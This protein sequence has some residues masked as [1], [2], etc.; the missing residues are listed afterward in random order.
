MQIA[1][2]FLTYSF[3][4]GH[5]GIRKINWCRD[6]L[7]F[8]VP[9]QAHGSQH[10]SNNFRP[11]APF[12]RAN[13]HL[14]RSP[15]GKSLAEWQISKST[16]PACKFRPPGH[17]N[18]TKIFWLSLFAFDWCFWRHTTDKP[19]LRTK[20]L[21]GSSI[22][23][24]GTLVVVIYNFI[25]CLTSNWT[26]LDLLSGLDQF[27][28]EVF[29]QTAGPDLTWTALFGPIQEIHRKILRDILTF[30]FWRLYFEFFSSAI[31]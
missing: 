9:D 22:S 26:G 10:S 7:N 21:H 5:S 30:I 23:R 17:Q 29:H 2:K 15:M 19:R 1:E 28:S 27:T 6:G 3:R 13:A 4:T 11:S 31:E 24:M 25:W 14:Y 18:K 12:F 20:L 16:S 8:R